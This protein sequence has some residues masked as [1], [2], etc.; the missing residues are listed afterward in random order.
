VGIEFEADMQRVTSFVF[1]SIVILS[2]GLP[3]AA[4]A[5]P[6]TAAA[7]SSL[8]GSLTD[9]IH[10]AKGNVQ[11]TETAIK[12][13]V[14]DGVAGS[15]EEGASSISSVVIAKAENL[16]ASPAEIGTG[17]GQAS[18]AL[19][20]P[21]CGGNGGTPVK[22][23]AIAAGAIARSV[24]DEGNTDEILAYQATVIALHY[25]KLAEIVRSG[26]APVSA[27][28]GAG[29]VNTSAFSSGGPAGSTGGGCLNAS[30]TK[31]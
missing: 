25:P 21:A 27:I 22:D 17:L 20:H 18:V 14:Q 11:A 23:C 12:Q 15:G 24:A 7:I 1:R 6:L 13:A 29:P 30:C 31:P 16:G 28:G 26:V 3:I 9:V 4:G 10:A 5:A 8:Q 2:F 19:A